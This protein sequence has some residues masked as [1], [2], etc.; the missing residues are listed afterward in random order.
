MKTARPPFP[1]T[2]KKQF[3]SA[4]P[5]P[6]AQTNKPDDSH[7]NARCYCCDGRGHFAREYPEKRYRSPRQNSR[8][9]EG[10]KPLLALEHKSVNFITNNDTADS[11][12]LP[13]TEGK[14]NALLTWAVNAC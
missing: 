9:Q 2:S 8:K 1:A 5:P 11:K 4:Q 12:S 10:Q 7:C 6:K 13:W 14:S 3:A